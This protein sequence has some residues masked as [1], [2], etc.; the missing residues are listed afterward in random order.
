MKY[1]NECT[2]K[3]RNDAEFCYL[4][5]APCPD[6]ADIVL[7]EDRLSAWKKQQLRGQSRGGAGS[8]VSALRTVIVVCLLLALMFY[9]WYSPARRSYMY[10]VS[11]ETA[12]AEQ[13]YR[14]SVSGSTVESFLLRCMIPRGAT[15]VM[16][17]YQEGSLSY[18]DASARLKTLSDLESP[19]NNAKRAA[20]QLDE[21]YKSDQAFALAEK[22]EADGDV[23][24][25]M[26]SY[27]MV[28]KS[29]SRYEEAMKKADEMKDKYRESVLTSVGAPETEAEYAGAVSAIEG[30]LA[31]LPGDE[32]LTEALKTLRQTFAVKIKAQTIP[33]V[34]S[35]IADGYYKQAI[36]LCD[37]ALKYNAQDLDLKTMRSEAVS[38]YEDFV[39]GQV[40]IYMRNGDK[41]GALQ[42]LERVRADL[43]D[44]PVAE[45]LYASVTAS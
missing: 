39:R 45:Q 44:D 41:E 8:V 10:A 40:S 20:A 25:A 32:T 15:A 5:G 22:Y 30:A 35:Y 21:L 17:A 16:R 31:V 29:D 6:T 14:D 23:R 13:L 11:G 26:L 1:C 33:T 28:M 3:L 37:R 18:Q 42:L 19:L 4:C 38:N 7:Y 24:S 12:A 27:S 9:V 2:T 34:Q 36:Q 43:P